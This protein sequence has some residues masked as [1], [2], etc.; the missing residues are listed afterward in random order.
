MKNLIWD[1]PTRLF[2]WMFAGSVGG[3]FLIAKVAEK[4]SPL[5]YLHVVFAV[6]AGLLILWR[7]YWG[8][9]GSRHSR[10]SSFIFS[11]KETIGYFVNVL[12]GQS[13]YYAG[14]NPGG[15]IV[16]LKILGATTLTVLSG[17]FIAQSEIFE[18][19]HE[20]LAV[21]TMVL[22]GIHIAGVILATKMHKENYALAMVTGLKKTS[23][24]EEGLTHSHR[25]AALLMLAIVLV[26]WALFIKGF[27]REK[28]LFT[29]PGTTWTLQVGEPE[30]EEGEG[31]NGEKSEGDTDSATEKYSREKLGT[32]G[33]GKEDRGNE[34]SGTEEDDLKERLEKEAREES[35]EEEG[36]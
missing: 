5:F 35:G 29:F 10:F 33:A 11:I 1:L 34:D 18:E 26:P 25:G 31:D 17:I 9:F 21:V 30:Y 13:K 2:H 8:F 32:E 12:T 7:L 20:I 19:M 36:N 6:L 14:H 15:S 4:E 3:A 27:D 16:V 22:V 23:T 24:A 28:A